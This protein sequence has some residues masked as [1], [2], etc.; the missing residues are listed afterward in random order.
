MAFLSLAFAQLW[1]VFNM[2][3]GQSRVF[4]NEVTRN[5]YVWGALGLCVLL[6][7]GAVYL[8]VLSDVLGLTHPGLAG[9][10]FA[11]GV[12]V[13]PLVA[14]QIYKALRHGV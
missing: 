7:V 14:G 5:P 12:S 13:L 4:V 9:W 8:P 11:V 10:L 3:T 6:L 1:H 2:R